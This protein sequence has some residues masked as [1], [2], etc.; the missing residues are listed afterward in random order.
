MSSALLTKLLDQREE[1]LADREKLAKDLAELDEELGH[2][3]ALIMT[4]ESAS[5]KR[6]LRMM[7]KPKMQIV[8]K[9]PRVRGVLAAA[10]R[11]IEELPEPFDKNQLLEKLK[12]DE[13]FADK[14]ITGP[15]IRNALRL[16]TQSGVL[17]V[18]SPATATQCAKYKKVA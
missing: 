11:A 4:Y 6:E 14:E 3:K 10:K 8:I 9:Q 15:N 7:P 5:S 1:L 17:R 18:E 16:L 2:V 13:V 12:Q